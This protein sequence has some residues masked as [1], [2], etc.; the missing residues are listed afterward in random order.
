MGR[1]RK[2]QLKRARKAISGAVDHL[3][4]G[5]QLRGA[6][7]TA[8]LAKRRKVLGI[9]VSR[10]RPDWSKIATVGAVAAG[11]VG[12]KVLG[13][14]DQPDDQDPESGGETGVDDATTDAIA[15][16]AARGAEEAARKAAEER[17]N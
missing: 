5:K 6:A 3:D 1:S 8:G 2:K 17:S 4:L 10:K 11:I 12:S 7:S 9:P 16:A 15:T 14:G 13:D